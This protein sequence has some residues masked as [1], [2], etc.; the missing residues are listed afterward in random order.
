MDGMNRTALHHATLDNDV[1]AIEQL[2]G[3][4]A[5]PDAQDKAGFKPL[6]LLRRNTQ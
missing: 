1:A 5:S 6:H 3:D 4:G 2:I